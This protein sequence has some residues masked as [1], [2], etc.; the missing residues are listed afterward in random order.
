MAV[1]SAINLCAKLSLSLS[2]ALSMQMS[3]SK[4][5]GGAGEG[6]ATPLIQLAEKKMSTAAN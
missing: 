4:K 3:L 1:A 6:A 5:G 2:F